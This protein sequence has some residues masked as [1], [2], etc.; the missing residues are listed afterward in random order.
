MLIPYKPGEYHIYTTKRIKLD[1][2]ITTSIAEIDFSAMPL[3]IYPTLNQGQFEIGLPDQT[4][5]KPEI[6]VT[7]MSGRSV[8]I[9]TDFNAEN[10][11]VEMVHP[12]PGLYVISLIQGHTLYTGKMFVQ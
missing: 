1:F 11:S 5:E 2:D 4:S 8:E 3:M 9:R 6:K 12:I 10:L 7:D